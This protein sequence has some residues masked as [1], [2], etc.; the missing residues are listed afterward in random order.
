[1][2]R[3]FLRAIL[4]GAGMV[5]AGGVAVRADVLYQNTT[6]S[7]PYIFNFPNDQ[8]I[9]EQIWLGTSVPEYLTNFSFEYYSPDNVNWSVTAD[10][11]FYENNGAP[12]NG[13]NT[14]GTPFYDSGP[15]AFPNPLNYTG[16][17]TNAL[18]AI[19]E[20]SDLQF[21]PGGSPLDPNFVLPSNFTFTVTFSG[22]TDGE[23]VDLPYFDP[24][25]VGA[26]A[27]DYW[28][29]ASGTWQLLTNA[30]PVAF[31]AEF[32]GSPQPTP[33]PSVLCLG[34]LGGAALMAMVRRRQRRG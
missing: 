10:V 8:Q 24:P 16:G 30:V 7:L 34:A 4:A 23:S 17:L 6:T 26:N 25:T 9:G 33:E 2:K 31:G 18:T 28:F 21:P 22:L 1:M 11:K 12:T 13:Y 20:L 32:N 29:D 3:Y 15:I 5:L 19:F 14:P 27:G